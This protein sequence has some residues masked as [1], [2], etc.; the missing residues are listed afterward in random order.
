MDHRTLLL[1]QQMMIQHSVCILRKVQILHLILCYP[2]L[3]S[4][5]YLVR[6]W[7]GLLLAL[8]LVNQQLQA[9]LWYRCFKRSGIR[10]KR[11]WR[12]SL[13]FLRL[14][15]KLLILE[16]CRE[17]QQHFKFRFNQQS[18]MWMAILFQ[19]HRLWR[20]KFQSFLKEY[21]CCNQSRIYI[22]IET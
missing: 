3:E 6:L 17:L 2:E 4:N 18:R 19:V 20:W 14:S 11:W 22:Q 12:Y 7:M 16:E 1:L 10:L 9:L 8:F 15:K 13:W 5:M 21:L